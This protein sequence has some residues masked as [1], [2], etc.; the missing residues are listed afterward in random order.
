MR[1]DVLELRA[2]ASFQ[3]PGSTSRSAAPASAGA[4]VLLPWVLVGAVVLFLLFGR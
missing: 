3:A 4:H 1:Y 2:C